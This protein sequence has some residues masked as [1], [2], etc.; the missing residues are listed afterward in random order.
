MLLIS[1][2]SASSEEYSGCLH[3]RF[4]QTCRKQRYPQIR[5]HLVINPIPARSREQ[6]VFV[7]D[8]KNRSSCPGIRRCSFVALPGWIST[9]SLPKYKTEID[10]LI[11][12]ENAIIPIEV[13]SDAS[14]TGKSLTLYN[15]EF[16]PEI[17]IRYS[18][19][20]LKQDEGL[21]NIPL[22]MA[23]Y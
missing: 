1:T 7:P 17:R 15:K 10:F 11:Q 6:K 23:D 5:F 4:F 2:N 20:N 16:Q 19:K 13:K 3:T 21:L 8:D 14:I 22:F 9:Q 18:L 12:H